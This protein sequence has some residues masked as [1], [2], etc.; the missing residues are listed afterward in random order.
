MSNIK[1]RA[2]FLPLV[3]G[4]TS[5]MRSAPVVPSVPT[6]WSNMVSSRG[7]RSSGLR[8]GACS[9]LAV[10]IGRN[11]A[12]QEVI[13]YNYSHVTVC[14]MFACAGGG[15]CVLWMTFPKEVLC[16]LT[17]DTSTQSREARRWVELHCYTLIGQLQCLS[18]PQK[19]IHYGDEYFAELDYIGKP[20]YF[21]LLLLT[22]LLHSITHYCWKGFNST[23]YILA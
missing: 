15:D 2:L 18:F 11:K 17:L 13:F 10:A 23:A 1:G 9:A 14:I 4:S 5:A 3:V 6:E 7:Y 20:L 21:Y 19:A 22:L 8:Q 16:A 12:P